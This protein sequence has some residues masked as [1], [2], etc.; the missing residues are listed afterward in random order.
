VGVDLAG[1]G[2]VRVVQRLGQLLR[3]RSVHVSISEAAAPTD[4]LLADLPSGLTRLSVW[5][6]R[7]GPSALDMFM[8]NIE[9]PVAPPA[10]LPRQLPQLS[11]LQELELDGAVLYPLL[12]RGMPHLR[13]LEVNSC[14]LLP[15]GDAAADRSAVAALLAAVGCL[16]RLT[17]LHIRCNRIDV[18]CDQNLNAGDPA[19]YTALTASSALHGLTYAGKMDFSAALNSL[20][21]LPLIFMLCSISRCAR[22]METS[23]HACLLH[24]RT[25]GP[26]NPANP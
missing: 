23:S 24:M 4:D 1:T 10:S 16:Q 12:L 18:D 8:G 5:D 3:P 20:R 19:A 17:Q 15:G 11:S 22:T 6:S 9:A 21:T 2:L 13:R 25:S 14:K 7:E 26:C